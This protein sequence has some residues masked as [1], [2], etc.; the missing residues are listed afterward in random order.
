[1]YIGKSGNMAVGVKILQRSKPINK[2]VSRINKRKIQCN[3]H[4]NK[5]KLFQDTL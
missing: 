5:T 1:M 4:N 3:S 2:T